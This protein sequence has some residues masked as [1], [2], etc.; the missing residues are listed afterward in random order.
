MA[1]VADNNMASRYGS[2]NF[3]GKVDEFQAQWIDQSEDA[4][5]ASHD[6]SIHV[7]CLYK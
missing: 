1:A 4:L 3:D 6:T 5:L 2:Y 7:Y